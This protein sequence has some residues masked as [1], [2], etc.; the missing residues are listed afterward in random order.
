MEQNAFSEENIH[1]K[2]YETGGIYEGE[3]LNGKQHGKGKYSLPN[4]YSYEGEWKNGR[5]EGIGIAKYPDGS[6]Y[7]GFFIPPLIN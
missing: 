2:Q 5:I 6:I 4:G 3:F 7:D 1:I